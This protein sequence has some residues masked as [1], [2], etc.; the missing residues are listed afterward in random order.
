M[1]KTQYINT[2]TKFSIIK[3]KNLMHAVSDEKKRQKHQKYKNSGKKGDENWQNLGIKQETPKNLF[4]EK[5]KLEGG[6][7]R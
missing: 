5:N 6:Q 7:G 3:F 4:S 2:I 1:K